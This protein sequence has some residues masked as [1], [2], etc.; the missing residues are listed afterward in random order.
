[1]G[2]CHCGVGAPAKQSPS[3]TGH[4]SQPL[5]LLWL[6]RIILWLATLFV[7][8]VLILTQSRGSYLAIGITTIG[9]LFLVI[10]PRWRLWLGVAVFLVGLSVSVLLYRTGGWEGFVDVLGLSDQSGLS[11]NTLEGRLEIWSRAI[12]GIQDFP[13]TGMGMNT[14]REVVHVLYPLF[15]IAPDVD[16]AHA[17]NQYLQAALDLG[18]PGLIAFLSI[19]IV[20]FWMLFG[21]WRNAKTT[22][23]GPVEAFNARTLNLKRATVLGLGGGLAAHM[24][25]GLTDAITLGA[26][27]GLL[28]WMLLGLIAGLH[29]QVNNCADRAVS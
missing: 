16:I 29:G 25:F 5:A 9:M 3:R 23:L 2:W 14:F 12:Y 17:H 27:P 24:L 21:I 13:F 1:M 8:A 28:W 7:T 19:H 10:S 4:L 26:K 20:A 6:L 15:L 22:V 18:I 11:I